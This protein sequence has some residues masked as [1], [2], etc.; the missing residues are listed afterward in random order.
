M[1]NRSRGT[2]EM[3]GLFNVDIQEQPPELTLRRSWK[4]EVLDEGDGLLTCGACGNSLVVHLETWRK[5][6]TYETSPCPYCF[7]TGKK[8]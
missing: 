4:V 5:H 8:A 6:S 7:K 3:S 2:C 1:Y